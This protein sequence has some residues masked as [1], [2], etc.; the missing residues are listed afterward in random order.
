MNTRDQAPQVVGT[1]PRAWEQEES[2]GDSLYEWMSR[3]PWLLISGALHFVV[4]LIVAAIPWSVFELSGPPDQLDAAVFAVF[5]N[6]GEVDGSRS[7][8]AAILTNLP[9][10]FFQEPLTWGSFFTE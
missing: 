5:D 6:D 4:F 3:A 10:V 2:F 1:L 7:A 9:G 8:Q